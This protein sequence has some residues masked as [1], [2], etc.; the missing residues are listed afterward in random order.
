MARFTRD[1]GAAR[2]PSHRGR[3]YSYDSPTG[4]VAASWPPGR[5]HFSTPDQERSQKLFL[6][7]MR[8]MKLMSA[9]VQAKAYA[10][11]K[12]SPYLPR[13]LLLM[14]LY[15]RGPTFIFPDG[16][17]LAS[18]PTRVNVSELL[19]GLGWEPGTM[20]FRGANLWLPVPPGLTGQVLR[21]NSPTEAPAWAVPPAGVAPALTLLRRSSDTA[22]N[23]TS[24]KIV[25]WQEATEDDN[26]T[27]N[28]ATPERLVVP[29]G[30]AKIRLTGLIKIAAPTGAREYQVNVMPEGLVSNAAPL[31]RVILPDISGGGYTEIAGQFTTPFFTPAAAWYQVGVYASASHSWAITTGTWAS[32]EAV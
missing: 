31:P 30:A 7:A 1:P 23:T 26:G 27:W 15:G 22:S 14:M 16:R 21:Y 8:A 25:P 10:D 18:M 24:P 11:T 6:E 13:D 32:L 3:F 9:E 19:D 17:R 28:P 2:G 12:D 29:A 5:K 4:A 20:L